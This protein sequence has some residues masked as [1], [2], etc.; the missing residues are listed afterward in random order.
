MTGHSTNI[1]N[2]P[3]SRT[4][5]VLY[6]QTSSKFM[7]IR[8]AH[9][10]MRQFSKEVHDMIAP[11]M[12]YRHVF[13]PPHAH[14]FMMTRDNFYTQINLS[15]DTRTRMQTTNNSTLLVDSY[16]DSRGRC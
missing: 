5:G 15:E 3:A 16:M 4:H 14:V 6:T 8:M 11:V 13:A 2:G 1:K 12:M 9:V 7:N 10:T